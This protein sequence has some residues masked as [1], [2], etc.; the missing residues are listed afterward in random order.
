MTHCVRSQDDLR[1]WRV[2]VSGI[3]VSADREQS[4]WLLPF[5]AAL[6]PRAI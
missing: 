3:G 6:L 2:V 4:G 5:F 1:Q